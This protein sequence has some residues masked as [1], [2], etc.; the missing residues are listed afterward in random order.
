MK[1]P[2]VFIKQGYFWL[3]YY[4]PDRPDH[5]RTSTGIA[6]DIKFVKGNPNWWKKSKFAAK[7]REKI[8]EAEE[9]RFAINAGIKPAQHH[10]PTKKKIP[11]LLT[12]VAELNK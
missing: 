1:P 10:P 6:A 5:L 8:R 11:E 4:I 9:A 3:Q 7:I 2:R 12:I